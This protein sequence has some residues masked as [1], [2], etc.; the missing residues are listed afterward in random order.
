MADHFI[1]FVEAMDR[2]WI[3]QRFDDLSAFLAPDVV[4]VAPDGATRLE[5]LSAAVESY[6]SFMVRA[7]IAWFKSRDHVVTERGDAA[8]VEYRWNMAWRT[9]GAAHEATGRE[10][11]MLARR[12]GAWRIVWRTQLSD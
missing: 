4:V 2:C 1:S 6:R 5:G 11:V 8:I 12:A 3:E 9:D 7:K 10:I